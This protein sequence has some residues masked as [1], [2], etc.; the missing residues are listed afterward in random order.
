[1]KQRAGLF[2]RRT[3]PL[4][5]VAVTVGRRE[6]QAVACLPTFVPLPSPARLPNVRHAFPKGCQMGGGFKGRRAA[7]LLTGALGMTGAQRFEQLVHRRPVGEGDTG[8]GAQA[9][10]V[11]VHSRVNAV[12]RALRHRGL[13]HAAR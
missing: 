13:S 11:A 3:V 6:F 2:E 5:S 7:A 10:E 4:D 9:V 12:D 8:V 1:M